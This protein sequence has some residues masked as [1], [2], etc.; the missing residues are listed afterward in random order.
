MGTVGLCLKYK[1]IIPGYER[2]FHSDFTCRSPGLGTEEF[3]LRRLIQLVENRYHA[4]DEEIYD[5][6]WPAH[7]K[8]TGPFT[9]FIC[10]ITFGCIGEQLRISRKAACVT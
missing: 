1:K 3:S 7:F 10:T 5:I 9:S 2:K 6:V 4:I 8:I